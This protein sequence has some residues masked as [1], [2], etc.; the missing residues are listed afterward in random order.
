[1]SAV[2]RLLAYTRDDRPLSHA[3]H[4]AQFGP[5]PDIAA[6]SLVEEVARS[7]LRGRGGA[8]FP[9]DVKLRAVRA[10]QAPRIVVANGAEGEPAS[11][12]DRVLLTRTP[13]LVVDGALLA[14][15]AVGA[16]AAAICTVKETSAPVADAIRE[17]PAE[18]VRMSVFRVEATYLS[19]EESALVHQLNGG[20][21]KPTFV[22]P[23]PFERG[24]G[25][26]PTLVQNVETLAHLAEIAR[27]GADWFRECGTG[28]DPGTALIT[29][30]GAVAAP[31]VYEVERGTALREA[32]AI[33]G[34]AT[35]ALQAFLV[36]GYFGTWFRAEDAVDL[37]LGSLGAGVVMALPQASCGVAES[38]RALRYLA[39]A[40]SGQCGPCVH[41]LAAIAAA[42]QDLAAARADARAIDALVRWSGQVAGRGACHHP[43]G[44]VRLLRSALSVFAD[45]VESHLRGRC[46]TPSR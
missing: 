17:R 11:A 14:A 8:D 4:V 21:A 45:E 44:A 33:A 27:F 6:E 38:A 2:A 16:E 19:G 42:M 10:G 39:A 37:E 20:P 5:L 30:S 3:E 31:G 25:G 46:A 34:G 23:R 43:N 28:R 40:S 36:G 12:K 24:V 13:H 15:R 7:G 35:Q 9:V 26:R 22:P 18:G 41:G 32:V 29:I 1:V